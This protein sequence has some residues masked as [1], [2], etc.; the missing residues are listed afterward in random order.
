MKDHRRKCFSYRRTQ[1]YLLF[2]VNVTQL[3]LLSNTWYTL[4]PI[5]GQC[6]PSNPEHL[7]STTVFWLVS[8]NSVCNFLLVFCGHICLFVVFLFYFGNVDI[9]FC[10]FMS[11]ENTF[12]FFRPFL[13]SMFCDDTDHILYD[14]TFFYFHIVGLSLIQ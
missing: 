5:M 11:F 9:S 3:R 6:L 14:M 7:R 10:K 1:S 13:Y 12:S 8:C 4:M 2:G